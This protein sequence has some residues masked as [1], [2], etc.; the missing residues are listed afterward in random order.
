MPLGKPALL[1]DVAS[2]D[3]AKTIVQVKAGKTFLE[4]RLVAE[5]NAGAVI[6]MHVGVAPSGGIGIAESLIS[7]QRASVPDIRRVNQARNR[8]SD[9]LGLDAQFWT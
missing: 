4:G 8:T 3:M 7:I 6:G 9:H 2:S 1:S 5:L